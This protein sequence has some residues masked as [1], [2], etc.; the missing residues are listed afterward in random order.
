MR[1][2]RTSRHRHLPRSRKR[3]AETRRKRKISASFIDQG[4]LLGSLEKSGGLFWG[5]PDSVFDRVIHCLQREYPSLNR[6]HE[7]DIIGVEVQ[8]IHA[9][10]GGL[11]GTN[12][13]YDLRVI[14]RVPRR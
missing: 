1:A 4:A 3:R 8:D 7:A 14:A 12:Y 6:V 10:P 11:M 5:S 2:K 13:T 9:D